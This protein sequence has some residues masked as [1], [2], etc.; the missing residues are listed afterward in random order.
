MSLEGKTLFITGAS[1]GIGLAIALRAARDGANVSLTFHKNQARADK[2]ASEVAALGRKAATH[3][4]N[5]EDTAA[6]KDYIDETAAI[7][8][9]VH[10]IVYAAGPLVPLIHLSKVE[11][12]QMKMHLLQDTFGF[13]NVIHAALPHLRRTRGSI[14]AC[15]TAA[16]FRYAAADGLSI[17][18]KA[19]VYAI[20]NGVAREEGRYGVRANG[21]ALGLIEAGQQAELTKLGFIDEKYMQAAARATPLRRNGSAADVAEAVSYLASPRAG[22]V[23]GQVIRVDGGYSI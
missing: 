6:T 17:V 2:V 9:G 19:G 21:V 4:L 3:G 15:Q 12:A 1:R 22:F 10:T 23:T 18:P 5:I 16:F 7:F 13:F 8:G 11:P 14:V 20:M